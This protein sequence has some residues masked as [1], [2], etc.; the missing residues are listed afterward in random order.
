MKS[1]KEGQFGERL[2]IRSPKFKSCS[3]SRPCLFLLPLLQEPKETGLESLPDA[4]KRCKHGSPLGKGLRPWGTGGTPGEGA[5]L[6]R[7][8]Q[9]QLAQPYRSRGHANWQL[10]AALGTGLPALS[11]A[12]DWPSGNPP[13]APSPNAQFS[14]LF[15]RKGA[16][17]ENGRWRGDQC[18]CSRPF[19]V[20]HSHMRDCPAAGR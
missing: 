5:H 14:I 8:A 17:A 4:R 9:F 6:E 1:Q 3:M 10:E 19:R 15:Q 11:S 20:N 2:G 16:R 12:C 7:D 18:G 13:C